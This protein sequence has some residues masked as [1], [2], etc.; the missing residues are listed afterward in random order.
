MAMRRVLFFRPEGDGSG[1]GSGGGE[2]SGEGS[3]TS[4]TG[5]PQE[6]DGGT[7]EGSGGSQELTTEL[8]RTRRE[9]AKYRTERNDLQKRVE[10]LEGA[11]KSEVEKLTGQVTEKDK[12]LSEVESENRRLRAMVL[13]PTVGIAPAAA[14]DAA[15]LLDWTQIEDPSSE[16]QVSK[17]L[18]ELV[19]SKPYLGGNVREGA[20]GGAGGSREGAADMNS[21]IRGA[22]GRG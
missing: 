1:S 15:A 3:G 2:G 12:R 17:A 8:E 4:T 13:A 9:A 21:L 16:D 5:T 11:G 10:E 20:D 22:A 6:G 19:K 18:K 7:Q 14:G